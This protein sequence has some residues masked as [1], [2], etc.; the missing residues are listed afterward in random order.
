L[1]RPDVDAIHSTLD[2]NPSA[3]G[4][5]RFRLL[6]IAAGYE[7]GNDASRA[8][9]RMGRTTAIAAGGVMMSDKGSAMLLVAQADRLAEQTPSPA[10]N[11]LRGLRECVC[12]V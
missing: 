9:L 2:A 8:L 11:L 7:D 5:F 1:S 12:D 3:L 10:A 4:R 6:T